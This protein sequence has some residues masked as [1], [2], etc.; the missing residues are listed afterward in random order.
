MKRGLNSSK[1]KK[2]FKSISTV[3]LDR[4]MHGQHFKV[5][6]TLSSGTSLTRGTTRDWN[7]PRVPSTGSSTVQELVALP[8]YYVNPP[9]PP[10]KQSLCNRPSFHSCQ[11]LTTSF[12]F[13]FNQERRIAALTNR[14]IKKVIYN[15]LLHSVCIQWWWTNTSSRL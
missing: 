12:F 4:A 5:V 13:F 1:E 8:L 10:S 2:Y 11:T 15:L 6:W 14:K 3:F 9:S 7:S